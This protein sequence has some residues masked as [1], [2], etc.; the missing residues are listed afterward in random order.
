MRGACQTDRKRE[1]DRLQNLAPVGPWQNYQGEALGQEPKA[2]RLT[3]FTKS[4][5]RAIL[6][7]PARAKKEA[8]QAKTDLGRGSKMA[9]SSTRK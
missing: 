7:A 2:A 1:T 6:Y 3:R 4:G 9:I 5:Q 8:Q